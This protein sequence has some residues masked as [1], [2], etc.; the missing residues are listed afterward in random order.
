MLPTV[1]KLEDWRSSLQA[2]CDTS[3]EKHKDELIKL[4]LKA[5][6][7]VR[8][9]PA[10]QYAAAYFTTRYGPKP[11]MLL[12]LLTAPTCRKAVGRMPQAVELATREG[13]AARSAIQACQLEFETAQAESALDPLARRALALQRIK[14][15]AD[16]PVSDK[17]ANLILDGYK[18]LKTTKQYKTMVVLSTRG[19][20]RILDRLA[21]GD[22][23]AKAIEDLN[24][25]YAAAQK[26]NADN[27]ALIQ[28]WRAG[29][30]GELHSHM[31]FPEKLQTLAASL[32]E[33]LDAMIAEGKEEHE[34]S[35]EESEYVKSGKGKVRSLLLTDKG[36][37]KAFR[38]WRMTNLSNNPLSKKQI[39]NQFGGMV[40]INALNQNL[41][42]LP[43]LIPLEP[44]EKDLLVWYLGP[45]TEF[46]HRKI[47]AITG[48]D[49][50]QV[51]QLFDKAL[52]S[53]REKRMPE[54]LPKDLEPELWRQLRLKPRER[55]SA[56]TGIPAFELRYSTYRYVARNFVD[57]AGNL[58]SIARSYLKDR[59]V[60]RRPATPEE[61]LILLSQSNDLLGAVEELRQSALADRFEEPWNPEQTELSEGQKAEIRQRT[62]NGELLSYIRRKLCR[63]GEFE[64]LTP[65]IRNVMISA[66]PELEDAEPE[67][68][69]AGNVQ[70]VGV[71]KQ[72]TKQELDSWKHTLMAAA[73]ES[74][75]AHAAK[76]E[77]LELKY[78]TG[79]RLTPQG[80]FALA[81]FGEAYGAAAANH[82]MGTEPL[83]FY[84][85]RKGK[86]LGAKL[87]R[88]I[89]DS[90]S[91]TLGDA[92]PEEL[93]R[94]KR[95]AL[96][97]LTDQQ[98][99]L[100]L[101]GIK[102][103][104]YAKR[105]TIKGKTMVLEQLAQDR[106]M[107][108]IARDFS[109][110]ESGVGKIRDTASDDLA[111]LYAAHHAGDVAPEDWDLFERFRCSPSA[112]IAV[113]EGMS[114][115]EIDTKMRRLVSK[116][117][118]KADGDFTLLARNYLLSRLCGVRPEKPDQVL[119]TLGLKAADWM[120]KFQQLLKHSDPVDSALLI[121]GDQEDLTSEQEEAIRQRIDAGQ[122]LG[123][124]VARLSEEKNYAKARLLVS[125]FMKQ[126]MAE[127]AEEDADEEE[128]DDNLGNRG[129]PWLI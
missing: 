123:Y 74:P 47:A 93:A 125:A 99:T 51:K 27:G 88:E 42:Q 89:P 14:A 43:E 8:L 45:Q 72:P 81:Y 97:S 1:K 16:V 22:P 71:I 69:D 103:P 102:D 28:E 63:A 35:E 59:L 76:V 78:P 58:S 127:A 68:E 129:R 6:C 91:Q 73:K 7:G 119:T 105:L 41:L 82:I 57:D 11:T 4:G 92:L 9:L 32:V 115:T 75:Q 83:Q 15:N 62:N 96:K 33:Q 53:T 37:N 19:Q 12:M 90:P 49:H 85:A 44:E 55:I 116:S 86:P 38:M 30:L 84:R 52:G 66:D 79:R 124:I 109:M 106:P 34:L 126:D 64:T 2:L 18:E 29:L 120:D 80:Q 101:D 70:D 122:H 3:K 87:G 23:P 46:D 25:K 121:V 54:H 13:K 5:E 26:L 65:L 112:E 67:V 113:D 56:E 100:V 50:S 117:L 61:L 108:R 48:I 114:R 40:A 39:A 104:L 31:E 21:R 95:E 77:E 24:V 94:V 36:R 110:S 98:A 128:V 107:H 118:T 111:E 10:G 60:G 17:D 20:Q